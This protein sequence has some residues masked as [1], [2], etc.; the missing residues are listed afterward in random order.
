MHL[1]PRDYGQIYA[2]LNICF[3]VSHGVLYVDV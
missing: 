2:N 3:L 1:A